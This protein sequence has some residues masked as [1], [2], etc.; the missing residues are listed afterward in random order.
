MDRPPNARAKESYDAAFQRVQNYTRNLE[1][2][3]N[4]VFSQQAQD[5]YR[6]WTIELQTGA[7]SRRCAS[8]LESHLLKMP[9][10]I[11]S[12]ALLFELI[13]GGRLGIVGLTSVGRALDWADYLK[14]H[15][16]R[17]YAAGSFMAENGARL[18]SERRD[19]LPERFTARNIQQKTWA[20]L[21]DRDIIS[22]A[23][24]RL[25][26]AYHVRATTITGGVAGG[27]PST[28]YE[29]NPKLGREG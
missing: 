14:S 2:P 10:T 29:W 8:A 18:I 21:Y 22:E 17:L 19:Q 11:A 24:N 28:I 12:L 15:A 7:R 27:R 1:K 13:A 3:V 5:L 4:F 26:E 25:T 23:L 16:E 6:D 20:G 9:K